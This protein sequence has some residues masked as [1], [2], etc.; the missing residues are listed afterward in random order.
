MVSGLLRK[1]SIRYLTW[2]LLFCTSKIVLC[3]SFIFEISN[4]VSCIKALFLFP[5]GSL[6]E[7][8]SP[9]YLPALKRTSF[10][11]NTKSVE[12]LPKTATSPG[13]GKTPLGSGFLN[14]PS[15]FL[16]NLEPFNLTPLISPY[17]SD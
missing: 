10:S 2:G 9:L 15:T 1:Y 6:S 4:F 5:T 16:I 14:E 8:S 17:L 11:F 3:A 7:T 13:S 12:P